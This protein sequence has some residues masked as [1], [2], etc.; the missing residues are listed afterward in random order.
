M[1]HQVSIYLT[2]V[3]STTRRRY[4]H[5]PGLRLVLR[6]HARVHYAWKASRLCRSLAGHHVR[7]RDGAYEDNCF[8]HG[9][10][11]QACVWGNLTLTD[12]LD[13]RSTTKE[14]VAVLDTRIEAAFNCLV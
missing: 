13:A 14:T 5:R 12:R 2:D 6:R 8:R 9:Y 11:R 7:P 10:R 1:S 3:S 4:D